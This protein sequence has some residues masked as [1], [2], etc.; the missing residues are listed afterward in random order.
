MKNFILSKE[1]C[2]SIFMVLFLLVFTVNV[3]PDDSTCIKHYISENL[4]R[5]ELPNHISTAHFKIHYDNLVDP[6]YAT[7]TAIFAEYAYQ[8]ICDEFGWIQP[9]SDDNRGG[10]NKYDIYILPIANRGETWVELE[11]NWTNEWAPSFV[12]INVDLDINIL[13]MVVAHEFN[14]A[15]QIAYTYKDGIW[16]YENTAVYIA[17]EVYDYQYEY[18]LRY[19]TTNLA[20]PL[21]NPEYGVNA[22]IDFQ[23]YQYAGFLWP[24]FIVE[25]L[26]DFDAV[27][28]I[29]ERMGQ[30][31]GDHTLDDIDYV[32]S[33]NYNTDLKTALRIY[34]EWRYFTGERNDNLHFQNVYA[35]DQPIYADEKRE[36]VVSEADAQVYFNIGD[37][38]VD[39]EKVGFV[40]IPDTVNITS[41]QTANQYLVSLPFSLTDNSEFFY[42]VKYGLTDSLAALSMLSGGKSISFKVEL[43]DA[44]TN[45]VL[46]V[47]DE[48]TYDQGNLIPYE[49]I[50]YQ[51]L[52][53]GIGER[54]VKMRLIINSN[55]TP[56]YSVAEKY[57]EP[58]GLAKKSYK[59][60]GYQGS[61]AVK[62]Y[63]L[64][65]N[66][67]NPFNP[68]TTI[69]WQSPVGSH[70]TNKVFDVL[71]REVAT[72]VNEWKDAGRYSVE[73]NG[74]SLASGVYIYQL[75]VNDFVATK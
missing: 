8:K 69:S 33:Q 18:Y 1:L 36:G 39:G 17:E 19:F 7:N 11:T 55:F 73:F 63:A 12:K 5:P 70:Q 21:S 14:H 2:L 60:I 52:T 58:S 43:L 23:L 44:Q 31:V 37:I 59:Q 29:W 46:G 49:K 50:D 68:T 51:V 9:P 67:P 56:S 71:G 54:L 45:E 57:E 41:Q 64:E 65:Q 13:K 22:I 47:F 40:E 10:D 24:K 6:T 20:N 30:H 16:F 48:V 66:Y 61:L 38:E 25:W 74:S 62:E 27:K 53:N 28:N 42:S 4:V 3:Y 26:N 72:L 32:L 34:A 35:N 15:C 75:R